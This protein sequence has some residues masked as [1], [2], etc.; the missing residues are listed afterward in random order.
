MSEET[1]I[2]IEFN[3]LKEKH[4]KLLFW[5]YFT[6]IIMGIMILAETLIIGYD[7]FNA[8]KIEFQCINYYIENL[9]KINSAYCNVQ[10]GWRI[11]GTEGLSGNYELDKNRFPKIT[12]YIMLN[13]T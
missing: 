11:I 7:V 10:S 4:D 8:K 1:T 2:A 5:V 6:I 9:C 12:P 3:N 13:Q